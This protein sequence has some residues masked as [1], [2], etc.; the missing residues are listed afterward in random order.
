MKVIA[1]IPA[2]GGSV[3]VPLKNIKPL[4]GR[5]LIEYTIKTALEVNVLDRVIVSTDHPKIAK[6][7]KACGA[8]VIKRPKE[9]AGEV[10]TTLVLLH[11]IETLEKQGEEIYCIVT[12]QP[13]SPFREDMDIDLAVNAFKFQPPAKDYLKTALTVMEANQLPWWMFKKKSQYEPKLIFNVKPFMPVKMEGDTLISQSFPTLY[14]L[15]GCVYVSD[16]NLIVR[17]KRIFSDECIAILMPFER[18]LDLEIPLDFEVA[19]ALLR[20]GVIKL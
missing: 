3:R 10:D 1:V 4:G 9:I 12:L 5:P 15:N 20:A 13:S 16:R 19:E 11:I 17:E 18:S 7:S 2:R 14:Y 6:I 8:E